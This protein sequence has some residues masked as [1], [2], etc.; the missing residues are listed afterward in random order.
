MNGMTTIKQIEYKIVKLL[1]RH[2]L[3]QKV[4]STGIGNLVYMV[5]KVVYGCERV[6]EGSEPAPPA[7]V[8]I[9]L[10]YR[11]QKLVW[12]GRRSVYWR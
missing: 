9:G 4:T 10:G 3:G 2:K 5:G 8:H 1:L 6:P 7:T 11:A 12:S